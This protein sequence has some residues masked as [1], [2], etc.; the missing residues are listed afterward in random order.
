M[1]GNNRSKLFEEHFDFLQEQL[2]DTQRALFYA[3]SVREVKFLQ[4]K[5]AYLKKRMKEMRKREKGVS[6]D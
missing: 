2:A 4:Q 6:C 1:N 5:I 3:R